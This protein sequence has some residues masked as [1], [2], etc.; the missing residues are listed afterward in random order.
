VRIANIH[1]RV[2]LL[3]DTG[4]GAV[5]V[6]RASGGRFGP[7]PAGVYERWTEFAAWA[8]ST[9]LPPAE[10]F[11]PEALGSPSPNPR[12]VFAIGLNYSAHAAESGFAPPE[13]SPS[14][15]TKFPSCITGPYTDVELIPGGH[16]DWEVELVVVIGPQARHV[17]AADAWRYVA[18]L[19]VG[20]D[21]SE[22]RLQ[23]ATTP[24]QFS[25][26]KSYPG[27]GPVGPWLV[28]PDEFDDPDDL[29]LGCSI[30]GE[31]MQLG[32]TRDLIFDVSQLIEELSKVTP[33]LPG[34]LIFT[35]TPEGVGFGRSP[36]RWLNP[37]DVL[38]SFVGGIGEIRQRFV[39]SPEGQR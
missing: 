1:G 7:Q 36:Q 8:G 23:M 24:P 15:F 17:P 32:R 2:A 3:D 34:D 13:T 11:D 29:A 22:R 6:E 19:A 28:T 10:A 16:N 14:V 9:P 27:F 18:G 31:Q 5:D 38:T 37:G 4:T 12:Q 39:A 26:G 25:M 33:L 20:Q 30:N 35:G 21:V